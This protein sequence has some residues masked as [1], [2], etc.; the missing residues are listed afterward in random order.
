MVFMIHEHFRGSWSSSWPIASEQS[1]LF[2]DSWKRDD[3]EDFETRWNQALLYASEVPRKMCCRDSRWEHVN[4]FSFKQYQECSI[5]KLIEIECQP[6]KDW[7]RWSEKRL[8][9]MIRTRKF[10]VWNERIE[11]GIFVRS[12]QGGMSVWKEEW[13]M[14]SVKRIRTVF[15]RKET[16][17]FW[18]REQSWTTSTIV[19]CSKG[20]DP[21]WRK[22]VFERHWLCGRNSYCWANSQSL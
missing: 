22:K 4:L 1:H 2:N 11:T 19:F 14:F 3:F 10:E 7:R 21:G 5:M 18:L 15:K 13:E 12:Q 16:L 9:Q 8:N 17:Q 6:I 20:I